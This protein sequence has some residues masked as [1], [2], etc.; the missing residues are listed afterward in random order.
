M[1]WHWNWIGVTGIQITYWIV[2]WKYWFYY[3][4]HNFQRKAKFFNLNFFIK[5]TIVWKVSSRFQYFSCLLTFKYYSINKP[6][7]MILILANMDPINRDARFPGLPRIPQLR[8]RVFNIQTRCKPG[9][10]EFFLWFLNL[11]EEFLNIILWSLLW[12]FFFSFNFV[13]LISLPTVITI[14]LVLW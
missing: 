4:Q 7:H 3:R 11:V 13:M 6:F 9:Y 5:L 1:S 2:K 12:K 10:W 8:D 14:E